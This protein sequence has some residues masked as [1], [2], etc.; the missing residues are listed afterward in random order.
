MKME[1]RNFQLTGL[2]VRAKTDTDTTGKAAGY[3]AVFGSDSHD[4]GGFIEVIEPGAFKRS[5]QAAASGSLNI[6]ALWSHDNALPLGSTQSGKLTL[7]EDDRGLAFELDTK[8]FS[9]A[10]LD[11]LEDNDLRM[12]F[13]FNVRADEWRETDT[14][15]IV[16]TL[17]DVDLHEVSFVINPA[18]PETEAAKRSLAEWRS[19][20]KPEVI[21]PYNTS[22]LVKRALEAKLRLRGRL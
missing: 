20:H 14:G 17:K 13:G 16:R 10:Q 1:T 3:A 5:L 11:A 21:T 8:R 22:A 12:S 19:A 18:Y 6:Y 7:S 9:A 2:E 15:M 4:L